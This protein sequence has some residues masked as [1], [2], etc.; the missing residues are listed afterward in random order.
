VGFGDA[1]GKADPELLGRL[2]LPGGFLAQPEHPPISVW[3]TLFTETPQFWSVRRAG[4][5]A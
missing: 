1:L 5:A 4:E 2:L 3:P